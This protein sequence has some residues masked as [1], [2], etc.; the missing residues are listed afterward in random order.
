MC[1]CTCMHEASRCEKNE[2][3]YTVVYLR[4]CD[5]MR[6]GVRDSECVR[7]LV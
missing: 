5:C 3:L 2:R 6:L 4:E 1:L 7:L